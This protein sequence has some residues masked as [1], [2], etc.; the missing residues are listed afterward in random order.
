MSPLSTLATA[1]LLGTDR[2]PP[3]WPVLDGPVGAMLGHIPRDSLEKALLQTVGVLGTCQLAGVL[4]NKN[5]SAPTPAA[6]CRRSK[7]C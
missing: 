7:C 6:E 5:D 1:A 3:D 4:P 2:R